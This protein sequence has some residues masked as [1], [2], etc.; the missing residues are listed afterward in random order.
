MGGTVHREEDREGISLSPVGDANISQGF[1][2]GG[3]RLGSRSF[4]EMQGDMECKCWE[5]GRSGLEEF[6]QMNSI[7]VMAPRRDG[8]APCAVCHAI[9]V[10]DGDVD[11]A[12]R[13]P[14]VNRRSCLATAADQFPQIRVRS[15]R[16]LRREWSGQ[17][18]TTRCEPVVYR[19]LIS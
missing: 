5:R 15:E 8:F 9:E 18:A 7:A 4:G 13:T 14:A 11:P 12:Q 1:W 10:D 3:L 2:D 17:V 16:A 6:I 19:P